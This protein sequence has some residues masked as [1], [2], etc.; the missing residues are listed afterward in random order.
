MSM[1]PGMI[2]QLKGK[3]SKG[4]NV[5]ETVFKQYDSD[6]ENMKFGI[7]LNERDS[8][9]FGNI[10]VYPTGLSFTLNG[11]TVI[12]M[13]RTCMYETDEPTAVTSLSFN[14]DTPESVIINYVIY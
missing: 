3:F 2:G 9:P 6:G 7:S 8:L 5:F 12:E 11:S 14:E 13:G 1:T 10:A 4:K